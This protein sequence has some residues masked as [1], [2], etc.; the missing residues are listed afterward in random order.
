M[1]KYPKNRKARREHERRLAAMFTRLA[2]EEGEATKLWTTLLALCAD[3]ELESSRTGGHGGGGRAARRRG[4][5][6]HSKKARAKL[7]LHLYLEQFWTPERIA[8]IAGVTPA[9]Q[10]TV[11]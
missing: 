8:D 11:R 1:N 7:R 10:K 5:V 9:T 6:R 2:T 4:D 3:A